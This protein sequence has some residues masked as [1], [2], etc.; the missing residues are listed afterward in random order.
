[1]SVQPN[2]A[3]GSLPIVNQAREPRWVRDGSPATQKAYEGAL[4]F[5]DA[6]VE[7]LARS[8]AAGSGLG[9][10]SPQEGEGGGEEGSS[11]ISSAGESQLSSLLPQALTSA[12]MNGGGLGLAAQMT[13]ADGSATASGGTGPS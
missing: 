9:G 13:R 7:Q 1:M 6:L 5:E 4:A 2:I 12:V 3:P 10:E 11:P 8:L